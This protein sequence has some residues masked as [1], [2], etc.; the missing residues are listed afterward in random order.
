MS[1]HKGN[2]PNDKHQA[3]YID[4]IIK[5]NCGNLV[6]FLFKRALQTDILKIENLPEIKQ[7]ITKEKE[8]DFLR[9]IY[10][11][12][13]PDGAVVQFEFESKDFQK[14]DKRMLEYVGILHKRTE[15]PV[16]QFVVY[17]GVGKAK[18]NTTISFGQLHYAFTVINIQDFDYQDFLNS[19]YPEEVLLSLF[20]SHQNISTEELVKQIVKRLVELKG[21][22]LATKKFINQL[23]MLSRLRNLQNQT[24]KTVNDMNDIGFDVNTDILYLQGIE[25][26]I[27]TGIQKGIVKGTE[28]GRLKQSIISIQNM[29]KE[30]IKKATIAK[31]L[32]IE[33]DFIEKIQQQLTKK[34]KIEAALLTK[35]A[36]LE[37]IAKQLNVHPILVEILQE[38][39]KKK[40][41]K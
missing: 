2:L 34:D 41:R 26:G 13:Y 22:S 23:I 5:E 4:K 28:K 15:K 25:K 9:L 30:K 6:P 12:N 35:N 20:A 24:I 40:S 19:D 11:S 3:N 14:M 29:T 31:F 36:D 27:E 16:L 10:N 37:A 21:D 32:E 18:M 39:L 7:Q 17:L 8:P 1:K 38:D 33:V